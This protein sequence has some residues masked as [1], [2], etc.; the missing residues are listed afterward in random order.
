MDKLL[1]G[2]Y[3]QYKK[4]MNTDTQPKLITKWDLNNEYSTFLWVWALFRIF[5]FQLKFWNE[6][7]YV[8]ISKDPWALPIVALT[9][10]R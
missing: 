3:W 8:C 9:S 10:Y 5:A 7:L 1:Y 6:W 2:L 4:N